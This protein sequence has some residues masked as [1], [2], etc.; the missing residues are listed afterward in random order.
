MRSVCAYVGTE[1]SISNRFSPAAAD[2]S[3]RGRSQLRGISVP[4]TG[5]VMHGGPSE[6]GAVPSN[7]AC[8]F[9]GA[10]GSTI[11]VVGKSVIAGAPAAPFAVEVPTSPPAPPVPGDAGAPA[12]PLEPPGAVELLPP[13]G[14]NPQPVKQPIAKVDHTTAA[15]KT[16]P[17]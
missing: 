3:N 6:R 13:F 17:A 16:R 8:A 1:M 5:E 15:K 7:I 11:G 9:G 12:E 10:D 4:A 14:V 2:T